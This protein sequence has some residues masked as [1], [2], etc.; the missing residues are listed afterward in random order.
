MRS[1]IW[2]SNDPKKKNS[3][4]GRVC[5]KFAAKSLSLDFNF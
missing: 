1:L 3:K 5:K 4:Q 2:L